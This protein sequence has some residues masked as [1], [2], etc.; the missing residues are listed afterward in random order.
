[1]SK[2]TDAITLL[3]KHFDITF[4]VPDGIKKLREPILSLAMQGKLV[5]QDPIAHQMEATQNALKKELIRAL[6]CK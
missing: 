2:Q 1:M 5:P 6:G 4:A 3:E